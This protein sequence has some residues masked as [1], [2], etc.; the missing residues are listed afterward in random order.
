MEQVA[1]LPGSLLVNR[2]KP[3]ACSVLSTSGPL[4]VVRDRLRQ[5]LLGGGDSLQ[6]LAD[7][8]LAQADHALRNGQ[9]LEL[10]GRHPLDDGVAQPIG[11]F[12]QFIQ[13]DAPAVPC[14]VT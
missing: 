12:Q 2:S 4:T 14:S 7:P 11:A 1:S 5:D 13:G 10:R 9:L 6:N 8:C 3:A